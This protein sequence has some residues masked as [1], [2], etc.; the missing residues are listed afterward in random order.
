[1]LIRVVIAVAVLA[2]L[3]ALG[4]V[5]VRPSSMVTSATDPDVAIECD[6]S[7]GASGDACRAWGDEILAQG[8][9]SHTFEMDDLARLVIDRPMWGFSPSCEV[10]YFISRDAANRAWRE[11]VACQEG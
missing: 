5:L 9:P 1:M 7:T 10:D 4:Y 3:G 6:G 8:S 2:L 11:K